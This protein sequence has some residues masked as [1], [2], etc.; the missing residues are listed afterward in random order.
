MSRGSHCSC[1]HRATAQV[2]PGPDRLR[3]ATARHTTTA[4]QLYTMAAQG[5]TSSAQHATATGQ[6]RA[7]SVHVTT[8]AHPVLPKPQQLRWTYLRLRVLA[9]FVVEPPQNLGV[10]AKFAVVTKNLARTITKHSG[11]FERKA[12]ARTHMLLYNQKFVVV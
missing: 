12:V 4:A 6:L 10:L 1:C 8:T 2:R 9:N 3:A 5:R 11:C 7:V